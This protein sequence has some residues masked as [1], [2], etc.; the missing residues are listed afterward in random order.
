VI[1]QGLYVEP[2]W[3][4]PALHRALR[5][6]P[7]TDFSVA[8]RMHAAYLTA[9][10]F[11]PAAVELPIVF[12]PVAS[13]DGTPRAMVYPIVLLGVVPGENLQVEDGRW[14][15]RYIPA[16]IRRYPFL[17]SGPINGEPS[18]VLVDRAWSGLSETVGDPLFDADDKPADAENTRLFCRRV[19]ELDLLKPM[20]ADLTLGDGTQLTID[21]FEVVDEEKVR[22]LPDAV[23]LELHRNGMLML[24][25]LHLLSLTNMRHLVERKWRRVA[26]AAATEPQPGATA[27]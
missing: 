3:L 15:A 6:A 20:K 7:L 10:E 24:L 1:D 13:S 19:I 21:G 25:Q 2:V 4:D 23:V 18:R 9:K 22:T 8:G 14:N 16:S 27:G 5:I 17:S 11:P 26:A 12:V